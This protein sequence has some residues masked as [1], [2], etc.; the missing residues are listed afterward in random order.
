MLENFLSVF[1]PYNGE[2]ISCV[3]PLIILGAFFVG[4]QQLIHFFPPLANFFSRK[5]NRLWP[6]LIP[7]LGD[8]VR[9]RYRDLIT[10][11]EFEAWSRENGYE[12]RIGEIFFQASKELPQAF[13]LI[14]LWRREEIVENDLNEQLHQQGYDDDAIIILKKASEYFPQPQDMIRFAVREVYSPPIAAEFGLAE[15]FPEEFKNEAAKVGLSEEHA[16]Q[17][18]MSHWALPSAG[19]GYEMLHRQIIDEDTLKKLLRALDVMPYWREKLIQMSYNPLT[20]VDVRRMHAMGVLDETQVYESYLNVGYSPDDAHKMTQFTILYN[21]NDGTK[22]AGNRLKD[23]YNKNYITKKQYEDGMEKLTG[24]E[25]VAQYWADLLEF[26]KTIRETQE[27]IDNILYDYRRGNKD[28][29]QT[30]TSLLAL[31]LTASHIEEIVKAEHR[32]SSYKVKLP[33]K[34]DLEK[35]FKT[36]A[37]TEE[38]FRKKMLSLGYTQEDIDYYIQSIPKEE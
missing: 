17:Y 36:G 33:S 29:E 20:R 2:V 35:W 5:T 25:A 24:S 28:L 9:M 7:S 6:N 3:A 38:E 22:E 8:I 23:A 34:T 1:H 37:L 27:S 15:D 4:G 10:Q 31:N 18:W 13:D 16:L 30:K 19:Q 21:Q 12:E 26:D 32:R 14:R 11:A